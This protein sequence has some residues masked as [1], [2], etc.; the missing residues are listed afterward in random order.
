MFCD[1]RDWLL[2]SDWY[3]K[4]TSF[5]DKSALFQLMD[6]WRKV[7]S[8]YLNQCW[9][10][11]KW[12][13]CATKPEW[14]KVYTAEMVNGKLCCILARVIDWNSH[15]LSKCSGRP[16][17]NG[18]CRMDA[19]QSI[20][21]IAVKYHASGLK[22]LLNRLSMKIKLIHSPSGRSNWIF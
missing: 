7:N 9:H 19:I 12:P 1:W 5:D 8:H 11:I 22:L 20:Q 14:V 15:H 16:L 6:C 2:L 10:I 18:Q 17:H 21:A 4:T 3:N 13:Y